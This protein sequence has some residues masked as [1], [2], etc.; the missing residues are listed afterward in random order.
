VGELRFCAA[1]VRGEF[2]ASGHFNGNTLREGG[3]G[4]AMLL[5]RIV[6]SG[7]VHFD[8]G[9][10]AAGRVAMRRSRIG[11]DFDSTGAN[12]D[13]LGDGSWGS[14]R[15]LVL[16][17]ARID[18][19]LV[20]RELASP[21]L[22]AS[23]VDTRVGI[24]CDDAST[25]GER[26]SLDGF[27]YGRLGDGAPLD[28][29][30]RSAWLERQEPAHLAAQ[31][32]VQPWRRL[33]RVLRRM[34]HEHQAGSIA[35]RREHWLR[36]IGWVGSWAP[37][38][39]RWLPRAAHGMLGLLAGHG[40]RPGRLIGWLVA[41][42]LPCGGIYWA[43][44]EQGSASPAMHS[45]DKGFSPFAYSLDR[46]LPL[47]D[48]GQAGTWTAA[49]SWTQPMRWLGQAEAG[50]GWLAMLLLLASLAGWIDRDRDDRQR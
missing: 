35:L 12:F 24:L 43:A 11:G 32:R 6:V 23:F 14:G 45:A 36:R 18:G 7:A 38:A 20:L 22:G 26:L 40:Y 46:L 29:V 21:L 47:L 16:E 15:S 5:D 44:A 34:G 17:R 8:G 28:S 13:W 48:L 49:A 27:A 41:V 39:L 31:F 2:R 10:K 50:F 9:F 30:F 19:A 1:R 37:P 3:R 4:V 42:W 25:W 33:I